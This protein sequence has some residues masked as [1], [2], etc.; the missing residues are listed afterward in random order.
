VKISRVR[1]F[2][3]LI[4]IVISFLLNNSANANAAEPWKINILSS[5]KDIGQFENRELVFEVRIFDKK[6]IN[7]LSRP[8]TEI[9]GLAVLSPLE[10]PQLPTLENNTANIYTCYNPKPKALSGFTGGSALRMQKS[11]N[12]NEVVARFSCW[13]PIGMRAQEYSLTISLSLNLDSS[14]CSMPTPNEWDNQQF[15]LFGNV[16]DNF[17]PKWLWERQNG[18]SW[19]TPPFIT[20]NKIIE[21]EKVSVIR[22]QAKTDPANLTFNSKNINEMTENLK[23]K[24][25]VESTKTRDFEIALN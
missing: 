24:L 22:T 16:P 11:G 21:F 4:T 8:K 6:V 5:L 17:R 20:L 25:E 1:I 14:C 18:N 9:I 13:F 19:T 2:Q 3:L 7:F 10:V 12:E 15:F 23:K